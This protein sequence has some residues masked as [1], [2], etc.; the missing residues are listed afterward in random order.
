MTVFR[1]RPL[2][3][4]SRLAGYAALIGGLELPLPLPRRLAAVSTKNLRR[5]ENGWTIYPT[6]M[7]PGH[8]AVDHCVFALRYEGVDLLVLK[9]TFK[10]VGPAPFTAALR[11]K[12]TSAYLRRLGFLYEWLCGETLAVERTPS[13]AYANVV[14]TEL[15][16][17]TREYENDT[18]FRV[19]NNLPGTPAFC[20]LVFRT[21]ALDLF[22]AGT[23]DAKARDI[24][25]RTPR[26]VVA[27]AAAFLQLSDSKASFAIEGENPPADRIARWGA[28]IA[29]AGQSPLSAERL[30]GLQRRLIGS[31]RFIV[32][33]FRSLGG[34]IGRHDDV[35]QPQPDH[36]SA[37]PEDLPSLID[38][39]VHFDQRSSRLGLHPVLAAACLAFGFV[40]IHPFE[41]GNG[42]LHRFLIH[43]VLATRGYTPD[44]VT[45]PIS[46]AILHD[47]ARYKGVLEDVSR[48]LLDWIEWTP[49]SCGN[50]AVHNETAD[51]YRY[52]DATSLCEF[53]FGCVQRAI[54]HDLPT[55]LAFLA[56]RDGFHREVTQV[57]DMS[58]RQLDL[59]L[60]FLH[61]NHGRLSKRARTGEF[62]ALRDDE[63][64]AIEEIYI[65]LFR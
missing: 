28:V 2:P 48:P 5:Q 50:I 4:P 57:V 40:Y 27:C 22:V 14:D 38:G 30:E 56:A 32:L 19:R 35:G 15:Q 54:E 34:F 1:E 29:A 51:L 18:R 6:P 3:V 16:F 63:A 39:L 21:K 31:T 25:E 36:I 8:D 12:P 10:K 65:D 64:A 11:S 44:G 20:P 53:L 43:H 17:A 23:F 46:N 58:E 41:D 60:K 37:K 47:I 26:D 42:R 24:I 52:F 7:F 55:E 9:A 33:G 59:L 62:E 49:T 13:A 61:Q 45:V